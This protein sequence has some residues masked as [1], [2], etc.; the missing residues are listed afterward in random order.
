LHNLKR[1]LVAANEK[2]H[3]ANS[4]LKEVEDKVAAL[5]AKVQALETQ[6]GKVGA[7]QNFCS[8]M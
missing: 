3:Q 7:C 1:L 2:L 8:L 6:F 5:N 4:Q